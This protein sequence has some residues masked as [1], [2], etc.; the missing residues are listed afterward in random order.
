MINQ[1]LNI[2]LTKKYPISVSFPKGLDEVSIERPLINA[3][4]GLSIMEIWKD[5]PG[6]KGKYQASNLG[7]IKSLTRYIRHSK[8]GKQFH[9]GRILKQSKNCYGYYSK[10]LKV[11]SDEY[12]LYVLCEDCH[13]K[14]HE[15]LD[16]IKEGIGLV[17]PKNYNNFTEKL[18]EI[19]K[20]QI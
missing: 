5:I 6:Y 12:W 9:K 18:K 1:T 20:T 13:K 15:E 19:V 4:S 17:H 2:E 3:K 14:A 11:W 7:R 10:N 8:G 16:Y